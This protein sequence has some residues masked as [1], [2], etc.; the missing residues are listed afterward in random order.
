M[1]ERRLVRWTAGLCGV[2]L[3]AA[4]AMGCTSMEDRIENVV[5][6]EVQQ[7]RMA[8]GDFYTVETQTGDEYEVLAE[9]CE[10]D[11]SEVEMSNEWTGT[12][13]TG[14]VR[15]T[16]AED[17][18]LRTVFITG[19]AWHS[20]NDALSAAESDD[21]ETLREADESFE[22][23]IDEYGDSAW[24]RHQRLENLLE[25]RAS[26]RSSTDDE[27]LGDELRDYFNDF[28]QW[29]DDNEDA[30]AEAK[31]RVAVADHLHDYIDGQESSVEQLGSGDRRR[32]RQI[33]HAEDDG[34]TE[35]VEMLR[36]EF[37]E[38]LE[39]RPE[40]RQSLQQRIQTAHQDGCEFSDELSTD[41]IES[42]ELSDRI[43]ST[44]GSFDCDYEVDDEPDGSGE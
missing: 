35:R 11:M 31:A 40:R 43:S 12:I 14:P 28:V 13:S 25:L 27:V 15:W 5:E 21:E 37:E 19:A 42:R 22:D 23:A 9:L 10:L 2:G 6:N 17:Q 20:L 16:A 38:E 7:C 44:T 26:E 29:A 41:G 39:E 1:V 32:E 36:E 34:D 8:D 24:V 4:S 18:D 3:L 33:E 30:A